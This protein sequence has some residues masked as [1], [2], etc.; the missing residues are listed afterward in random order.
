M[1]NP[2]AIIIDYGGGKDVIRVIFS[3]KTHKKKTFAITF[4]KATAVGY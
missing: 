4:N 3:S 1:G 2:H